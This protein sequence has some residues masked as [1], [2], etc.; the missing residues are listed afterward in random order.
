MML[1]TCDLPGASAD[2]AFNGP[3]EESRALYL[4]EASIRQFE[5]GSLVARQGEPA[6]AFDVVA[7]RLV[8]LTQVSVNGRG[9]R[10]FR[11]T[12]RAVRRHRRG[13][14]F[15]VPRY[16]TRDPGCAAARMDARDA[17]LAARS[18]SHRFA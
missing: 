17:R 16:G 9:H 5:R 2:P 14:R 4:A 6:R 11:W 3:T 13:R 15:R 7:V 18:L 8:K 1:D 12:E 10:P